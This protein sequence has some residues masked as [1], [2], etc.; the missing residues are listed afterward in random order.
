MTFRPRSSVRQR[1]VQRGTTS[2]V[3]YAM[4]RGSIPALAR[5]LL[6]C[7]SVGLLPGCLIHGN[8]RAELYVSPSGDDA[9]PGTIGRPL[10]TLE[11]ARNALAALTSHGELRLGAEVSLRRGTYQIRE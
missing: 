7:C 4:D 6:V 9:A 5:V 2:V 10:R 11:G 8:A 1:L 3:R